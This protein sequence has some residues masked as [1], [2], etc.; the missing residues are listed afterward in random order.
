MRLLRFMTLL[1]AV[2]VIAPVGAE[3]MDDAEPRPGARITIRQDH[4]VIRESW[5]VSLTGIVSACALKDFPADADPAS[6]FLDG[7]RDGLTLIELNQANAA[8]SPAISTVHSGRAVRIDFDRA[9]VKVSKPD[10]RGLRAV[11][12]GTGAGPA[13]FDLIYKTTGITWDVHY[14]VVVRGDLADF[15]HTLS[16]D[17]EGRVNLLNHSTRSFHGASIGL[18]IGDSEGQEQPAKKPGFL[19]LEEDS[20]LADLWRYFEPE[21]LIPHFYVLPD[22]HDLPPG[23][24]VSIAHVAVQRKP[25]DRQVFIRSDLIP[26]DARSASGIPR[27]LIK[28]KNESDYGRGKPV[29]PGPAS[30]YLGSQQ[31]TIYQQAWFNHT[32]AGGDVEIDMGAFDGLSVRRFS[33]D[34]IERI[35]GYEQA[36]ELR[37]ENRNKQRVPLKIDEAPP[38]TETWVYLRSSAPADKQGRRLGFTLSIPA[39]SQMI[40]QYAVRV[41]TKK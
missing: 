7:S 31:S 5:R 20:P 26:T 32:P 24:L 27:L 11:L 8:A 39:E 18:A 23:R 17:V 2:G 19:L 37:I 30:V 1:G 25:I 14:D 9:P 33:R 13:A 22:R 16:V 4:A 36:Y 40:V 3:A 34:R 15:E 35:D 12:S 28:L 29:P 38:I 21:P 10:T 41:D 6:V